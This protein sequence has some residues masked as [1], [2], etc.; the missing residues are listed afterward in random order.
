MLLGVVSTLSSV[1]KLEAGWISLEER[2]DYSDRESRVCYNTVRHE[3]KHSSNLGV[4]PLM[5]GLKDQACEDQ[6]LQENIQEK[7][8]DHTAVT[9]LHTPNIAKTCSLS[10]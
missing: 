4:W 2:A 7:T 6:D 9:N 10:C 1:G 3:G 8:L 5:E